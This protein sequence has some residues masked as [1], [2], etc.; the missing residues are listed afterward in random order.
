MVFIYGVCDGNAT[1]A[2]AEYQ[3]RYPN[4]RKPNPKTIS[5]T[6]NTLRQ[7]GSLPSVN[8]QYE[9]DHERNVRE[10]ENILDIVHGSPGTSTRRVARRLG[11]SHSRVWRT[12][13]ENE[14]YPYHTQTV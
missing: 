11:C 2:A 1:A 10:E 7:S 13:K 12:L 6:F 5:G 3:R 14:M 9:R 4:R 8:I